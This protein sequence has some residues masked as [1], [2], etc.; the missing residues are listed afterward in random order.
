MRVSNYYN[1]NS[2]LQDLTRSKL[3]TGSNIFI[4]GKYRAHTSFL[5]MLQSL[6]RFDSI[7]FVCEV[8]G[9]INEIKLGMGNT[10]DYYDALKFLTGQQDERPKVNKFNIQ[11]STVQDRLLSSTSVSEEE[12]P[13]KDVFVLTNGKKFSFASGDE[14][15]FNG[16]GQYAYFY[17]EVK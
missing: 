8:N 3:E 12:R 10:N 17:V 1:N 4:G 16:I 13:F 11:A 6:I 2:P 5:D 15:C 9:V 7:R 14:H